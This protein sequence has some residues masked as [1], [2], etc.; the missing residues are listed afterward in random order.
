MVSDRESLNLRGSDG[1]G[2]LQVGRWVEHDNT[3]DTILGSISEN[4]IF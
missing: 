2:S 4:A 3:I 1:D